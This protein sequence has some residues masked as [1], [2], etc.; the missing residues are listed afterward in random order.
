V[1]DGAPSFD[2]TPNNNTVDQNTAKNNGTK[3]AKGYEAIASDLTWDTTGN[4]NCWG[5]NTYDTSF[6]ATLPPCPV[7]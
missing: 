6:P 2:S 7:P 1:C 4:G 3:P 5:F